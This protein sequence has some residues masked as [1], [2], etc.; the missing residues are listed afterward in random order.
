MKVNININGNAITTNTEFRQSYNYSISGTRY[1]LCEM[2]G[3]K[4]TLR[5]HWSYDGRKWDVWAGHEFETMQR[6]GKS[7]LMN[8]VGETLY[9]TD[10]AGNVKCDDYAAFKAEYAHY[11]VEFELITD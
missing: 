6:L 2:D 9:W 3:Q 11:N 10:K 1:I 7:V 8:K 5:K 4:V